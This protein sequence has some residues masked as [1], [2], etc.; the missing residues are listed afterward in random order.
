[1]VDVEVYESASSRDPRRSLI[2]SLLPQPEKGAFR[3]VLLGPTGAGKS[4]II[5]N[6]L[7][8]HQWG[9][10]EYFD[11]IYVFVGSLDDYSELQSEVKSRGLGDVISVQNK[12][13]SA[14]VENLFDEIE[15]AN[16]RTKQPE[17]TLFIFDDQVMNGLSSKSKS[18]I[19]DT[20]YVRGRHALCSVIISTQKYKLLNNNVRQ[21]NLNYLTVFEGTNITEIQAVV[22]EWHG[23]RTEKEFSS[24]LNQHLTRKYD[25]VTIDQ[26]RQGMLLDKKF[27]PITG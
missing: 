7:S 10:D 4:T 1:M 19:I 13:K 14:D 15:L 25:M 17:R 2:N 26:N 9:Y 27:K 8:N 20:L 22:E 11:T 3:W 23:R 6:V 21:A 5:K 12:F 18:N 24:I 16:S